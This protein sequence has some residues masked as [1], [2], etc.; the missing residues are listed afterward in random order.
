MPFLRSPWS[1]W[2]RGFSTGPWRAT[3][4][5]INLL[6]EAPDRKTLRRQ[7]E[8]AWP[9][10]PDPPVYFR[11]LDER[12][13]VIAATPGMALVFEREDFG[14]PQAFDRNTV[15][16]K[17]F[18]SADDLPFRMVAVR[19]GSEPPFIVQVARD[20]SHAE[21]LLADYRRDLG[22]VLGVAL[23]VCS[24][25][26]YHLARRGIRPVQ[27]IADAARRIRSSTLNERIAAADLPAELR[28]LVDTFNEMLDRLESSFA[29][30]TQFAADIAH[31]LRTPINNLRGE[32][33]VALSKARTPE[34][35]QELLD[36]ALEEY[37]R[38]TELID[39]LLFLA[40]AENPARQL[41]REP[42]D[43][44]LELERM[45][46]FYE[47]AAAEAGVCLTVSCPEKMVGR[48]DRTLLQRALGNLVS[49]AL[50]HTPATGRVTVS[51]SRQDGC[52]QIEVADT[53]TGLAPLHLPRVFDRFY[54]ADAARNP[55]KEGNVGL[56]L[57]IVKKIAELHGGSVA[58]A[59]EVGVGTR[60]TIS[61]AHVS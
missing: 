3:W 33:E 35:Y 58:I 61:F 22:L 38:L 6:R 2:P 44:G 46:D 39:S 15:R 27:D 18:R 49:N 60:V 50:R 48:L 36:S 14:E 24:V 29:R 34:Q 7:V 37:D 56:G 42:V 53:G 20:R 28:S 8:L 52:W 12:Q 55:G 32:A 31:E 5:G 41:Q 16:G 17:S 26:G 21:E 59:S 1:C 45:R 47:A 54:R 23:L 19:T 51:A 4:T 40:R 10:Q 11:V 25:A 43:L 13:Q 30:L 57:A 9:A